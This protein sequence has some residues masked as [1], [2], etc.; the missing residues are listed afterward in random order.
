MKI[1]FCSRGLTSAKPRPQCRLQKRI[2]CV[3]TSN[4]EVYEMLQEKFVAAMAMLTSVR[5]RLREAGVSLVLM[6]RK[7]GDAWH[8]SKRWDIW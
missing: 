2:Q 3:C 1:A 7:N 4:R 6:R 5:S 8:G